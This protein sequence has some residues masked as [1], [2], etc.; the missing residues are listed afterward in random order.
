MPSA[1]DG[2]SQHAGLEGKI[3]TVAGGAPLSLPEYQR[4]GRQMILP[5]FGLEAQL[6]LR[7]ARVLVVGAGGLG[8]PV[9]QQLASAGVGHIT[10]IDHDTVEMSNLAR[11]FLHT[12]QR[13]G[14]AKAESAQIAC[15]GYAA[16]PS[17]GRSAGHGFIFWR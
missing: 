14:M 4:Y 8:C 16:P 12:E 17:W 15:Q 9:I 13:I 3:L 10:V 7:A 6:R 5:G 2:T 11:Q 1:R